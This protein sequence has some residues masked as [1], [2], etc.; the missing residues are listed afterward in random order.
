MSSMVLHFLNAQK[1][2]TAHY[3]WLETC[4]SETYMKAN[5]PMPLP[6]LDVIVKA[7]VH[8]IPEKGHLGYCP[9]PGVVYITVDPANPAFCAN[10]NQS[11]ERMFAHELHHAARW[12]GPGYGFSLGEVL[13][14]EGLAGHFAIQLFGGQPE[15]W[16]CL[17][18]HEMNLYKARASR[19]W[20]NTD[21]NHN[22]W[23][24]GAGDLPRWLGYSLGFDLVAR[25][26]SAHPEHRAST[27]TDASAEVFRNSI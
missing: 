13:V 22:V 5:I 7:G 18:S 1:K 14:S 19:E 6:S 10:A 26:L 8:V 15:P 12:N 20:Q 16:E 3:N 4:L 27:L 21:Y 2:L 11:L 23:F 17:D 25:Y 9:E 24:F